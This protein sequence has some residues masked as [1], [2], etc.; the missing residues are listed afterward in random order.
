M[1]GIRQSNRQNRRCVADACCR[2]VGAVAAGRSMR[3]P[4]DLL[5]AVPTTEP[6]GIDMHTTGSN[7]S[8]VQRHGDAEL[9]APGV[10]TLHRAS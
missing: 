1:A 9:P 2:T 7:S 6:R 4:R 8:L 10:W 5:V 3:C